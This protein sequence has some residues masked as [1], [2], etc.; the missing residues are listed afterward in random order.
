METVSTRPVLIIPPELWMPAGS[1]P[2]PMIPMTGITNMTKYFE[3]HIARDSIGDEIHPEIL[4]Y[5][6][7][8]P[9]LAVHYW[10]YAAYVAHLT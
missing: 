10:L 7:S 4:F 1:E 9:I 3:K 8:D 5:Y 2:T 6:I